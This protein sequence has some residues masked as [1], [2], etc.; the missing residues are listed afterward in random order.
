MLNN[1]LIVHHVGG[2]AGSRSFPV[3]D[4][5]EKDI[6]NVMYEADELCGTSA[7][8]LEFATI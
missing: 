1:R 7:T 3:V 5:F 2:R 8:A 4:T 6:V